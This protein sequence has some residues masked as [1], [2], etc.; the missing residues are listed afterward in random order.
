MPAPRQ[1][2][3]FNP[4]REARPSQ[5]RP[6][7]EF[8]INLPGEFQSQTGSQAL[9]DACDQ[10]R[11]VCRRAVSIPNGK[12]GP[13]RLRIYARKSCERVVSIPNGKPGPLRRKSLILYGAY[14]PVS[15]PNGKPGPLRLGMKRRRTAWL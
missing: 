7:V 4:K 11:G 9:S 3:S 14:T 13:L 15:I 5:T 8:G 2:R 10:R 12:P 1:R 6:G